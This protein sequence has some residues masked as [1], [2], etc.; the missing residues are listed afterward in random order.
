MAGQLLRIS[1]FERELAARP[2]HV[3]RPAQARVYT[4]PAPVRA[5]TK[6]N[7]VRAWRRGMDIALRIEFGCVL[8]M[9]AVW[10]LW[11]FIR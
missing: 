10:L 1:D 2:R 5:R 7:S 6:K 3:S 11:H 8:L 9:G 4:F